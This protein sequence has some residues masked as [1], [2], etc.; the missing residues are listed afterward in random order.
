MTCGH[1]N[2]PK[3]PFDIQTYIENRPNA[4]MRHSLARASRCRCKDEIHGQNN[5]KTQYDSLQIIINDCA[6]TEPGLPTAGTYTGRRHFKAE[7]L[8]RSPALCRLRVVTTRP[9]N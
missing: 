3:F 4:S 2:R 1:L 7:S 8:P 9:C 6:G 5:V